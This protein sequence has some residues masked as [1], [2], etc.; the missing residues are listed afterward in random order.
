MS[1]IEKSKNK[2]ITITLIPETIAIVE[3]IQKKHGFLNKQEAIRYC[4]AFTQKKENPEYIEL[5]KER[6]ERM[7]R[8][9]EEKAD[10]RLSI[11]EAK[12]KKKEEREAEALNEKIENGRRIAGELRG[13]I[14]KDAHGNEKCTFY[15]Y[16]FTNP[17]NA[18][19]GE[20]T[21]YLDELSDND[22]ETQYMNT[23]TNEPEEPL[24][25]IETLVALGL[26]DK[27][28]KPLK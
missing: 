22:I 23:I 15:V 2:Y 10:E 6:K 9:P 21:V 17:Q 8:A 3:D 11:E 18:S 16:Q 7:S 13:T 25:V 12:Q 28:G 20:K 27:E 5:I 14:K 19:V 24:R 1:S 4:I 26:T